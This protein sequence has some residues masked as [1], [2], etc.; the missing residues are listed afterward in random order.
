M[1]YD[2]ELAGSIDIDV[3]PFI[4]NLERASAAWT[5]TTN[6]LIKGLSSIGD[7]VNGGFAS[8]GNAAARARTALDPIEAAFKTLGVTS[9][10]SLDRTASD[11][12]RAFEIVRS[13]A[14]STAKDIEAAYGSMSSKI[15]AAMGQVDNETRRPISS[16][17]GLSSAAVASGVLIGNMATSAISKIASLASSAVETGIGFDKMKEQATIGFTTMLGSGEKAKAFLDDLAKFASATPF[18][19][20]ELIQAAQK[21][22]A[23]GVSANKVI[24]YLT[25][26]GDAVAAMGGGKEM[27]DRVST[28]LVQMSAKGK[29]SA[30]EMRQLAEAGVPAWDILAKSIGKSIPDAMKSAEKGAISADVAINALVQGM[31]SRFGGMMEKQSHTWAGLWSTIEDTAT[32]V[33]GGVLEPMFSRTVAAMESIVSILPD[34]QKGIAGLSDQTKIAAVSFTGLSIAAGA[35]AAM[36]AATIGGP[37]ALA[38]GALGAA[39]ALTTTAFITNFGQIRSMITAWTGSTQISFRDV[40]SYI[41]A[42]ADAFNVLILSV[43]R[44]VDLGG[45]A[46]RILGQGFKDL[47]GVLEGFGNVTK[48]IAFFDPT[49]IT[50]GIAQMK[51]AW[52]DFDRGV[53]TQ[54]RA[55]GMRSELAF[56]DISASW[57]HQYQDG[58]LKMYDTTATQLGKAKDK[59]NEFLDHLDKLGKPANNH[60]QN[61]MGAKGAKKGKDETEKILKEQLDGVND[62]LKATEQALNLSST[63]WGMLPQEIRATFTAAE[64]AFHKAIDDTQLWG[65]ALQ[66]AFTR[67]G[68]GDLGKTLLVKLNGTKIEVSGAQIGVKPETATLD[69]S[70]GLWASI[71]KKAAAGS[72]EAKQQIKTIQ[73]LLVETGRTLH[74]VTPSISSDFDLYGAALKAAADTT[75]S[76]T[77]S[78]GVGIK[79]W[80]DYFKKSLEEAKGEATWSRLLAGFM[81]PIPLPFITDPSK[82]PLAVALR[83]SLTKLKDDV[84]NI[85]GDGIGSIVLGLADKFNWHLDTVKKWASDI[86]VVIGQMPGKFGQ[87]AKGVYSTLNQWSAWANGILSILHKLNSDI[88]SSLGGIASAIGGLFKKSQDSIS[89]SVAS[90]TT[91]LNSLSSSASSSLGNVSTAANNSATAMHESM[92]SIGASAN[93]ASKNVNKA[94]ADI[95]GALAAVAMFAGTRHQG[96]FTGVL[97][98]A[99]A[100]ATIGTMFAPGIGTAIGA[101]VGAIAGLFGSGKSKAQKEAEEQAKMKAGLDMQKLGA[102]ILSAQMEGLTKG[103]EFAKELNTFSQVPT[104]LVNQFFGQMEV[105]LTKFADMAGRFKAEAIEQSKALSEVMG[106]AFDTLLSGASLINAIRGTVGITEKNITDFT[107]RVEMIFSKWAVAADKIEL[108]AAKITGKIS[109]KLKTSFEFLGVVPDV[110]KGFAE[111]ADL[112][113]GKI[114][115][116][117]A[118]AQKIVAGMKSLSEAERGVELNKAGA[119]AGIFSTIFDSIKS[120]VEAIKAVADIGTINEDIWASLEAT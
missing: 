30:E 118:I 43:L 37:A 13:S 45:T 98:G 99:M 84:K 80:G 109:D 103:L 15:A 74:L 26:V 90:T 75:K 17:Q 56:K 8:I 23:M 65:A 106:S 29:V 53:S 19:F 1:S 4:R 44:G 110:I 3:A 7:Y 86:D 28:A 77:E 116:V 68:S 54:I 88:P 83:E 102:D 24:P 107:N 82:F 18:E 41:G 95:M 46:I 115:S 62:W 119:N 63:V 10:A 111:S 6:D 60:L 33:L 67:I 40:V 20:P 91:S 76:Q 112:T 101:G 21:F 93:S 114:D 12:V 49:S 36:V 70:A 69:I 108:S 47:V 25:A 72:E 89:S 16:F 100:G 105:F 51:G 117:F 55:F 59:F 97:G 113:G 5:K 87:V 120:S 42:T 50:T 32:Q 81:A 92:H 96:A 94:A 34:V 64:K 73:E 2:A 66:A 104:K 48:G 39:V 38:V 22:T 27:I 31:E 58:M 57:N 71:W 79:K 52:V 11:S 85:L 35:A 14:T 61:L 9:Q 78:M